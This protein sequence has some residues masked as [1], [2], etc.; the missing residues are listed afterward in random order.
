MY[1][2]HSAASGS[3]HPAANVDSTI[4]HM[5]ADKC[6]NR[7]GGKSFTC[8]RD[9]SCKAENGDASHMAPGSRHKPLSA[10][11]L[12][13]SLSL[14]ATRTFTECSHASTRHTP[15]RLQLSCMN[16]GCLPTTKN[17]AACPHFWPRT[18]SMRLPRSCCSTHP[19]L[20]TQPPNGCQHQ[21]VVLVV[22]LLHATRPQHSVLPEDHQGCE[23]RSPLTF[24]YAIDV[25]RTSRGLEKLFWWSRSVAEFGNSCSCDL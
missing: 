21:L 22:P 25:F 20:C 23:P 7:D 19:F 5:Q 4:V 12:A 24:C 17:F 16:S 3:S 14:I 10:F 6:T 8:F 9:R 15:K 11:K 18:R 2:R 1:E 13:T